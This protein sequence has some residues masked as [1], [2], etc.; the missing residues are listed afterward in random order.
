MAPQHLIDEA[1]EMET[2]A[3]AGGLNARTIP[4]RYEAL[5]LEAESRIQPAPTQD[6]RE[7]WQITANYW[8]GLA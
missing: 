4:S 1:A 3:A 8:W 6:E 7:F 5:A 2:R